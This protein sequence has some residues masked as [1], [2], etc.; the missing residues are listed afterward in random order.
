MIGL[1]SNAVERAAFSSADLQPRLQEWDYASGS[2][3]H[4]GCAAA[5]EQGKA[6]VADHSLAS[7]GSPFGRA[8]PPD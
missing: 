3:I 2:V 4:M 5:T 1:G 8:R 7:T 6:K